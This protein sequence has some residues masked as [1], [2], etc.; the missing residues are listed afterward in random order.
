MKRIADTLLLLIVLLLFL[1]SAVF[2]IFTVN[3]F[4]SFIFAIASVYVFLY[5]EDLSPQKVNFIWLDTT[6]GTKMNIFLIGKDNVKME[7]CFRLD[8]SFL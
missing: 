2:L 5:L 1:I 4:W 7:L 6:T 3:N 8:T